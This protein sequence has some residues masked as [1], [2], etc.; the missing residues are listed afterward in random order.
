MENVINIFKSVFKDENK[1]K[2]N[3]ES[4][5]GMVD[6]LHE[7]ASKRNEKI[8]ILVQGV[9]EL[10]ANVCLKGLNEESDLMLDRNQKYHNGMVD[11]PSKFTTF[12]SFILLYSFKKMSYISMIFFILNIYNFNN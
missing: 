8:R 10:G 9:G 3:I 5:K 4:V 2:V 7:E 11:D 12:Y 1:K 6:S